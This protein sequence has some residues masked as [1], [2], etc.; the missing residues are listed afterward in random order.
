MYSPPSLVIPQV[1]IVS[2]DPSPATDDRENLIEEFL[3]SRNIKPNTRKVYGRELRKF[4]RWADLSWREVTS[5]QV[6]LYVYWL[7]HDA[8]TP[9]GNPLSS[10]TVNQA[11][12]ALKS[13][14]G[15]LEVS[16]NPT[17]KI[18]MLKLAEPTDQRLTAQELE[19]VWEA[20]SYLGETQLR[21]RALVWI[22]LHGLRA[23]EVVHLNVEHC[24]GRILKVWGE[25]ANA[26][27][28]VPLKLDALATV[29]EYLESRDELMPDSPL[30]ASVKGTRLSYWGILEAVQRI[31]KF[32]RVK[33]LHP[34]RFRH[35]FGSEMVRL[36]D[37][38][39]VRELMGHRSENSAKRYIIGVKQEAA[40]AAFIRAVDET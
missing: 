25:K 7:R 2:V 23:G 3:N 19:D 33:D 8:K 32:S 38:T 37:P 35:T 39:H 10:S 20:I 18:E 12:T 11:I 21:D 4:L 24:Q 9:Q 14:Y 31:G 26:W 13:F 30:I 40:V 27:R 5:E 34:H 29:Q 1:E 16:P 22:L 15:W 17:R 36:I 6:S 28:E